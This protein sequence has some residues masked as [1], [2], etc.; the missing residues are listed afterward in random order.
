MQIIRFTVVGLAA[1]SIAAA[2]A[3]H[4][5]DKAKD[6][7][8]VPAEKGKAVVK[9]LHEDDRARVTE[10]TFKPGDV[11]PNI[12]R[13]FRVTRPLTNGTLER[14]WADG[15]KEKLERKAGEVIVAGPDKQA[16]FVKNVGKSDYRTY[17]VAIKEAKK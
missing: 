12:V 6:A 7:K 14:T 5:Q 10:T 3:V 17:T 9:V 4:A 1:F 16:F 15:K 11:G 8:A 13:G 2:G